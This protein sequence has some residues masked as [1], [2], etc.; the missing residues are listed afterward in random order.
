MTRGGGTTVLDS[1]MGDAFR[2]DDLA[3]LSSNRDRRSSVVPFSKL[4]KAK[5]FEK[6]PDQS[7]NPRRA[8]PIDCCRAE[9]SKAIVVDFSHGSEIILKHVR[10]KIPRRGAPQGIIA[11]HTELRVNFGMFLF[12]LSCGKDSLVKLWEVG[13]GRLVKQYVGATHTQLRCQAVFNDTEEF[14]L[15]M[16]EPNNEVL[17]HVLELIV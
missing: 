1:R 8:L 13:T 7:R 6:M 15:S 17:L 9:M 16:D 12:V 14:V 11:D 4:E 2:K 5:A 3:L 10:I